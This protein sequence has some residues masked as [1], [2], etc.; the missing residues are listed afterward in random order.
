MYAPTL[1]SQSAEFLQ[2]HLTVIIVGAVVFGAL[3]YGVIYAFIGPHMG[4][5][6]SM[7]RMMQENSFDTDMMSN[8]FAG[9]GI[10]IFISLLIG[11]FSSVF[12]SIVAVKGPTDVGAAF[13]ETLKG[14]FP[15]AGLWIWMFLR[16]FAWVP[17]IGIVFAIVLGPRFI[18][19][20]IV[21]LEQ[22]KGVMESASMSYGGT[23]GKW[24]AIILNAL[25]GAVLVLVILWIALKVT[26]FL[27]V[28]PSIIHYIGT[29]FLTIYG[30]Q[31]ARAVI[32][33]QLR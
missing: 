29:A 28:V 6:E 20:P 4:R 14:F 32:S 12:F 13:R 30:I 3:Q 15:L 24:G 27:P 1:L 17:L 5:I 10:S 19:A 21:L 11:L 2:K 26:A 7:T 31:L 8:I 25:V 9:F 33:G 22:G 23:K 16:S 18:L